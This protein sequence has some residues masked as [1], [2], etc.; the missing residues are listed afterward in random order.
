M[1]SQSDIDL[2]RQPHQGIASTH[3]KHQIYGF[4]TITD[5]QS[6]PHGF[7]TTQ[8][9]QPT[10]RMLQTSIFSDLEDK[11]RQ[12]LH[13]NAAYHFHTF[14]TKW[15]VLWLRQFPVLQVSFFIFYK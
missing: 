4:N 6:C 8:T 3:P 10:K 1:T 14:K 7:K 2:D 13:F 12:Y 5:F 15:R 9:L 11:Q